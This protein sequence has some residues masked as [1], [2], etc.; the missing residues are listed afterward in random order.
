MSK[1]D[2]MAEQF[3][4]PEELQAYS[5]AQYKTILDLNSKLS[6][7][8]E[9]IQK[10]RNENA[11]LRA[12]QSVLKASQSLSPDSAY[13]VTD[14]E[15][16]CIMQLALLKEHSLTRELIMD[17]V[18]RVEILCKTLSLI[19]SKTDNKPKDKDTSKMTTEE[20]MS[21]AEDSLKDKQ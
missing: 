18:K 11:K 7:A 6:N 16:I 1:I 13:K 15:S 10:L 4:S 20:L 14:E 9:E 2:K 5:E 12:E 17:E 3:N 19:R 8:T 21:W